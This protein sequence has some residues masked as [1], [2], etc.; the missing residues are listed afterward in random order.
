LCIKDAGQLSGEHIIDPIF[1]TPNHRCNQWKEC[2]QCASLR[3]ARF[4]DKAQAMAE[5]TGQL[6][7]S[8]I[9]PEKNIAEEIRRARSWMLRNSFASTGLWSIETGDTFDRLHINTITPCPAIRAVPGTAV[10]IERITTTPRAA[11]A[12]ITKRGSAPRPEQYR[13]RLI[14]SWGQVGEYMTEADAPP[15]VQGACMND[16]LTATRSRWNDTP[17]HDINA[18]REAKR[19]GIAKPLPVDPAELAEHYHDNARRHLSALYELL[20]SGRKK[21]RLK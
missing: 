12:Y 11:A 7:L 1:C 16:L 9:R 10:H 8:V 13:G 2:D 3:Q 17:E 14:G 20:E 6:Y 18:Y 4:A 19:L 21:P 5:R 15:I